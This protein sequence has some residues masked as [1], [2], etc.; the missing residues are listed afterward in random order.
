MKRK[1]IVNPRAAQNTP[2]T[3]EEFKS[4]MK[5]G[6]SDFEEHWRL[7]KSPNTNNNSKNKCWTFLVGYTV[8]SLFVDSPKPQG[9][10]FFDLTN[11][12]VDWVLDDDN[13]SNE[14]LGKR[15][16]RDFR[17]IRKLTKKCDVSPTGKFFHNFS[18]DPYNYPDKFSSNFT[19]VVQQLSSKYLQRSLHINVRDIRAMYER[20]AYQSFGQGSMSESELDEYLS[21]NELGNKQHRSRLKKLAKKSAV[22]KKRKRS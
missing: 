2:L 16:F 14:M 5:K 4:M 21:A 9:S 6:R 3:V 17:Q 20:W 10:F 7:F 18:G 22:T 11:Q 15:T 12:D 19:K 8:A 1:S 13:M